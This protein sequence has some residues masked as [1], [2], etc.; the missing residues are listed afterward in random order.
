VQAAVG[1]AFRAVLSFLK[2]KEG[3][4]LKSLQNRDSLENFNFGTIAIIGEK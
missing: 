2:I 4:S 1:P 3:G